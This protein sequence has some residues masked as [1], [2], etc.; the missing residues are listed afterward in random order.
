M[1]GPVTNDLQKM[2]KAR[3]V[4]PLP[5]VL[6]NQSQLGIQ[7]VNSE[8]MKRGFFC[9]QGTVWFQNR[10]FQLNLKITKAAVHEKR[11]ERPMRLSSTEAIR[12]FTV[13]HWVVYFI[14]K[15]LGDHVIK[16]SIWTSIVPCSDRFCVCTPPPG[17]HFPAKHRI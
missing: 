11:I 2:T 16:L 17:W 12:K 4:T 5:L 8:L 10:L 3:F 6:G 14:K 9:L 15:R 7:F 1:P 13:V